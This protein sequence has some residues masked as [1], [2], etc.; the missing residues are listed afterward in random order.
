MHF[1]SSTQDTTTHDIAAK[2]IELLEQEKKVLWL[3]SG[4]SNVLLEAK[5]MDLLQKHAPK[6]LS[7]LT[8]FGMDERFGKYGHKDSNTQALRAAKFEAGAATWIDIL[9]DDRSFLDTLSRFNDTAR[10]SFA[11]S[12]VVIG[13]FGLGNDGHVAG[14]LPGSPATNN[15]AAFV[16]G[17]EWE[18]YTRITLTPFALREI[19]LAYVVAFGAN[20]N[21]ALH[22]LAEKK[23]GIETL[24]GILLYDIPECYVY[25]DQLEDKEYS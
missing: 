21:E 25:N 16:E 3:T 8:I 4:G 15:D 20:K 5:I 1:V 18:D 11:F 24:P 23:E 14:V 22:R 13:Q 19:D 2:I 10:E 9:T 6:Q 12:D 17:Y 7:L